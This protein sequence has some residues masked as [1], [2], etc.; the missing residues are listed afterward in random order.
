MDKLKGLVIEC[1]KHGVPI[2]DVEYNSK[3]NELEY[4]LQGFSKSG[5]GVLT[6]NNEGEIVL[7]TRYNTVDIVESFE[8]IANVAKRWQGYRPE[9]YSLP[10]WFNI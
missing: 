3:N 2:T 6:V 1:L 9:Y 7:K 8:D 4:S 10:E 5:T